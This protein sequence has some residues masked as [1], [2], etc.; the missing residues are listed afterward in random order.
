MWQ[1]L[2]T[3][4]HAPIPGHVNLGMVWVSLP[5]TPRT[6]RNPGPSSLP[7]FSPIS[8]PTSDNVPLPQIPC[9]QPPGCPSVRTAP[10]LLP[11]CPL[12][13]HPPCSC[14]AFIGSLVLPLPSR[15]HGVTAHLS[16]SPTDIRCRAETR[17]RRLLGGFWSLVRSTLSLP[18]AQ[19][20]NSPPRAFLLL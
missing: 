12:P 8:L 4:P 3:F 15:Q 9:P 7:E 14:P 16:A 11:R 13:R 17:H 2:Q 20:I 10:S 6:C 1:K 5:S 19:V 18:P